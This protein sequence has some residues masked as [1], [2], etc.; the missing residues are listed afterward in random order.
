MA[1]IVLSTAGAAI[2]GAIGGPLGAAVGQ[3]IAGFVGAKIDSALFGVND[4]GLPGPSY[5]ALSGQ[6]YME[7][8]PIPRVYGRFR[9]AGQVIWGRPI[10]TVYSEEDIEQ[11]GKGGNSSS[12]GQTAVTRQRYATFALALC[13]GEIAAIGQMWINGELINQT[14][15]EYRLHRGTQTQNPDSTLS[16]YTGD[17]TP[18]YR[19]IAYLVFENLELEQFGT[20][21]LPNIEVEVIRPVDALEDDIQAMTIIPGASEFAYH[22]QEVIQTLD[23]GVEKTENHHSHAAQSNWGASMDMLE[24]Y[25]PNMDYVSLVV[26]WFGTSLDI[27]E[28]Q[29]VPAVENNSKVTQGD[30]WGVSGISRDQAHIVSEVDGR[31]AYGGTP[32]DASVIKAIQD[33]RNRGQKILLYPFLMMDIPQG[34]GLADPYGA[35]E[36]AAY[37]WRGRM[38]CNPAPGQAGSI[39]GSAQI[40]F[41]VDALFGAA[42]KQDFVVSQDQVSYIGHSDHAHTIR[43]MILHYAHLAELAGGVDAFLIGSEMV[44]LTRLK[45]D[46]GRFP[47]VD[48]Y[49][50]LAQEVREILRD[51][52]KISYAADWT[53]YASYTATD[54]GEVGSLYFPLDRLWASSAVDFVGIDY[55]P[56]LSDWR[57][58]SGHLDAENYDA[59]N[60][61]DYLQ[62]NIL[63]GEGYDW[64]YETQEGRDRQERLA[65]TDGAYNKPWV[66]RVKD[67][68]NWWQNNHYERLNGIERATPTS[69]VAQSKPIWLTEIGVPAV[70]LG[71]NQPNLFPDPKSS[72]SAYPHYSSGSRDDGNQRAGIKAMLSFWQSDDASKNPISPIYNDKMLSTGHIFLWAWDA[73]PYPYFPLLSEVWGDGDNWKTGHWLTGRLGNGSLAGIVAKMSEEYNLDTIDISG[74]E[75]DLVGYIIDRPMSLREALQPLSQAFSFHGVPRQDHFAFRHQTQADI[76]MVEADHLVLREEKA[77]VSWLSKNDKEIPNALHLASYD[78]DNSF[79]KKS[80]RSLIASDNTEYL[81]SAD[82]PFALS[83]QTSLTITQ[84]WLQSLW[85]QKYEIEFET[86]FSY[87]PF[88]IGD[89]FYLDNDPSGLA[90][91]ITALRY[92]DSIHIS[93]YSQNIDI[94]SQFFSSYDDEQEDN[95]LIPVQTKV[96][97]RFFAFELPNLSQTNIG[98]NL[99]TALF[100][101]PWTGNYN[102]S[103]QYQVDEYQF[104]HQFQAPAYLGTTISDYNKHKITQVNYDGYLDIKLSHGT[105][106]SLTRESFLSDGNQIAI[107]HEGGDWEIIQFQYADLIA[108]QQY[109]LTHIIRGARGTEWLSSNPIL[110]NSPFVVINNRIIQTAFSADEIGNE[111]I[112][113]AGQYSV[114]PTNRAYAHSSVNLTGKAYQQWRPSNM[115]ARILSDQSI[116][117]NFKARPP[118]GFDSWEMTSIPMEE[119]FMHYEIGFYFN[120]DLILQREISSTSLIL[121]QEEIIGVFG[122]MPSQLTFYVNAVNGLMAQENRYDFNIKLQ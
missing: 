47:A 35:S 50:S 106:D 91:Q 78:P 23:D 87:L 58:G 86:D 49:T 108:E 4:K 10:K 39:Y 111:I 96:K 32:S 3:T 82:L 8:Q 24:S 95:I 29:I 34:N 64:Y 41:D 56:P 63:G 27:A 40:S 121:S 16:A 44:S 120:N 38:T 74:L 9:L 66:Y 51:E 89:I 54:A 22:P 70:H 20:S 52:T 19:G 26:S 97:P 69:W 110:A 122:A 6:R 113:G 60:D 107:Q 85:T 36:Q 17:D 112:L 1:S 25:C 102:I 79:I 93:A 118:S 46:E 65:I 105:L 30:I 94:P 31:P 48:A 55:Y 83:K 116:E 11:G 77:M 119:G 14:N 37:P 80:Y 101:E 114:W 7:G 62:S 90:Y 18:A 13:E 99:T 12:G 103:R 109:R 42:Q 75:G 2:G 28:C 73:R 68:P 72:E 76:G 15:I 61:Q 53:E 115:R 100:A 5:E 88:E 81:A 43:R 117:I 67:L 98:L 59:V 92:E 45:N 57:S 71:T 104:S 33:L 21:I 84:R